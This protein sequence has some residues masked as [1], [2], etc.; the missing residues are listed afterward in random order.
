MRIAFITFEYPPH[1][2]GGAGVY[3]EKVTRELAKLGH[4]IIVF[5]PELGNN[6][7]RGYKINNLEIKR[8]KIN[9]NLPFKALHFWL[10][11]PKAIKEAE[12]TNKFDIIHFN[13][14][15]YWFL[16]KKLSKAPHVI[17]VHHLVTDAIKCNKPSL[18]SQIKDISSE[19]SLLIPLVEERCIKHSDKIFAVS[20]FTK[21]QI[22]K[23][24]KVP[25]KK[26]DVIYNG[27][28]ISYRPPSKRELNKLRMQL[29]LIRKPVLLFV[30]RVDDPRKGL[31]LLLKAFKKVLDKT[32]ATL[33]VV[34]LGNQAKSKELADSLGVLRNV[35]FVGV[36][37]QRSLNNFYAL[38]NVYVCPS[39][40]EG[41][42]LTIL[43][44]IALKKAVVA[45]KVGAIP[46]LVEG[47]RNITLVKCGDIKALADAIVYHLKN[48]NTQ[49]YVKK[50][51]LMPLLKRFSWGEAAKKIEGA[52]KE[53]ISRQE[54]K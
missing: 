32:N 26:I 51:N 4:E 27:A 19:N 16:E 14:L 11:L 20:N 13:S 9:K 49:K 18:I 1:V 5:T 12:R 43:E 48:K 31:D 41:F 33:L 42:G 36:V 30:G 3:A 10:A 50:G 21:E 52:Y 22:A 38:C 25:R 40:L 7:I 47:G 37:D 45:T 35:I 24:Y 39:R 15:S 54:I 34:G 28:N 53:L 29:N 46:E 6:E 2:L 17:T 23:T 8:V 44:A